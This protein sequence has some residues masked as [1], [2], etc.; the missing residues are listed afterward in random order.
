MEFFSY[1]LYHLSNPNRTLSNN[2]PF[3]NIAGTD[4]FCSVPSSSFWEN[5]RTILNKTTD[6][7]FWWR[8][9]LL[10]HSFEAGATLCS[11]REP[12]VN[13][14]GFRTHCGCLLS[15]ELMCISIRGADLLIVEEKKQQFAIGMFHYRS[16]FGSWCRTDWS[17]G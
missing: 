1:K 3:S 7:F 10:S 2:L 9:R 6:P 16:I 14:L 5:L 8:C 17:V 12:T 15:S 11:F 4:F 13:F